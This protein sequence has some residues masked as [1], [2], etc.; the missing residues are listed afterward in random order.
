M[1]LGPLTQAASPIPLHAYA[2][3]AAFG[4]GVGQFAL[5]KGTLPHRVAG[6][7]W[8]SLM[9]AVAVSSFFINEIRLLGP[10]SPIH[11]PSILTLVGL[12][13]AIKCA[14]LGQITAHHRHMRNLFVYA[15]L[16]AGA[17]TLLPGRI[18]HQILF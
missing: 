16:L 15:L 1:T 18:M 14:R 11:L 4:L 8:V 2:A 6:W 13:Q 9:M 10:F 7:L 17:F 5:P 3:L 12:W